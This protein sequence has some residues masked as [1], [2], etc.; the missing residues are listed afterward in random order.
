MKQYP[1]QQIID[2]VR[3]WKAAPAGG[4]SFAEVCSRYPEE[5]REMWLEVT[6]LTDQWDEA[7]KDMIQE[8]HINRTKLGQ[9]LR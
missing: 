5:F 3:E 7:E 6:E 4:E 8:L 9:A 2:F 1:K